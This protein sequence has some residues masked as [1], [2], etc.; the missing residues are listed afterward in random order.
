MDRRQQKTRE[1]ISEA[2]IKLLCEKRLSQITIQELIDEANIGRSTFYSHFETKDELLQALCSD[3]FDDLYEE[4]AKDLHY[5]AYTAHDSNTPKKVFHNIAYQIY[6]EK[7]GLFHVLESENN[8]LF[9]RYFKNGMKNLIQKNIISQYHWTSDMLPDDFLCNYIAVSY[10]ES[11]QWGF[12]HKK[13][14]SLTNVEDYFWTTV[15][16]VIQ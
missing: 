8:E 14:E 5:G 7:K 11:I 15:Q 3:L 2:L 4:A 10:V 1:A 9:L 12:E 13:E 16:P 6:K